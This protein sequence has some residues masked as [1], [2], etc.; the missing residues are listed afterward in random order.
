MTITTADL[1]DLLLPGLG[2]IRGDYDAIE[3]EW[4]MIFDKSTSDMA[5]ERDVQMKMLGTAQL[6]TEGASIVYDEM[7]ERYVTTYNHTTV[8][9]GFIITKEAIRDNLYKGQF[10]PGVRQLKSSFAQTKELMGAAVLN[11]SSDT[12]G[13][14]FGGDGQ[15]LLSTQH[16]LDIGVNSNTFATQSELNESSLQDAISRIQKFRDEAGLIVS[17]QPKRLVVGTDNQWIARRLFG[18]DQTIGSNNNDIN[19]LKAGGFLKGGFVVNR[20]LTNPKSWFLLTDVPDALR[21]FQ[22]DPFEP[23]MYVDFDTNNLK[24]KATERYSFG[25]SD[26]RGIFGCNP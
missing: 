3:T 13:A 2:K 21:Y 17:V 4:S 16:P 26:H 5:F 22:R 15:P 7:G 8:G 12:S 24:T 11:F 6:K 14:Y 9:L 20:F 23:D 10:A 18:T 19:A 25:F 1:R